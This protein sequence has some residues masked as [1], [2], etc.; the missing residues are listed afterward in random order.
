ME[1]FTLVKAG[2]KNRKGIMTGF[3]ILTMLIVISV[4]TMFGVRKNFDLALNRAFEVED[5]GVIFAFFTDSNY[6]EELM[7]KVRAQDTVDHIEVHDALV[8]LNAAIGD[9]KDSNGYFIIKQPGTIPIF[10]ED[11]TELIMPDSPDYKNHSLKK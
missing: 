3:M 8:G 1:I 4:I 6:S 7:D 11:C 2:I 10:N 9:K 5:K